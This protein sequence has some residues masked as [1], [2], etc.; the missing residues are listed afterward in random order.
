[1]KINYFFALLFSLFLNSVFSQQATEKEKTDSNIVSYVNAYP[2]PSED[3]I[4]INL[5]ANFREITLKAKTNELYTLPV[6]NN[7]VDVSTLPKGIYTI[8]I[9]T[10]EGIY[11][12]KLFKK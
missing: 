9:T 7:I 3:F 10:L 5:E 2:N 1:M 6:D 4:K 11:F 8:Q 12:S